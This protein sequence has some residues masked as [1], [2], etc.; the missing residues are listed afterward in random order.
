MSPMIEVVSISSTCPQCN[1]NR[2]VTFPRIEV[3][4]LLRNAGEIDCYCI[5]CDT[6]WELSPAERADLLQDLDEPST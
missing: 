3:T 2:A 5:S 6:K 1:E 4:D